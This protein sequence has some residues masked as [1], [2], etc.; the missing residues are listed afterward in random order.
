MSKSTHQKSSWRYKCRSLKR[1]K[2][3]EE[4]ADW[5]EDD[6]INHILE[7]RSEFDT[8]QQKYDELKAQPNPKMMLLY[9]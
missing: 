7:I 2:E 6:F 3:R 9:R 4:F 1:Q 5:S 8:L